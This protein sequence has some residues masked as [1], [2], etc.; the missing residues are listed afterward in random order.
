MQK[1]CNELEII[2]S[3]IK[4]NPDTYLKPQ[5]GM[6]GAAQFENFP[7]HDP[8]LTTF[9]PPGNNHV[10]HQCKTGPISDTHITIV[11]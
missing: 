1:A 5:G 9:T 2:G 4:L 7:P 3:V 10:I 6:Y 8:S 11:D